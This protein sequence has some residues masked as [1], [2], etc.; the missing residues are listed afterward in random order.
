MTRTRERYQAIS[1]LG[2]GGG[3]DPQ[4]ERELSLNRKIVRRFVR[5]WG[6][7]ELQTKTGQRISLLDGY[8]DCCTNAGPRAATAVDHAKFARAPNRDKAAGGPGRGAAPSTTR[9]TRGGP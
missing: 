8:T 5:A 1:G 6:V 9:V 7:E 2:A 4:I 3:V